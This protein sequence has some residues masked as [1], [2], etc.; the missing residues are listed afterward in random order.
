MRRASLFH[1]RQSASDL[2]L[3]S[4][5]DVVFQLLIFFVW[6]AGFQLTEYVLPSQVS[7]KST[8]SGT[9]TSAEP[10][11]PEADFPD[12]VVRILWRDGRVTWTVNDAGVG[13]LPELRARLARVYQIHTEAPLI[14]HPDAAVPLGQVIDVYDL[15]RQVGFA[16]IQ[17]AAAQ[18]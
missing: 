1:H 18:M 10:P 16:K 12:L 13:T 17:F 15:A 2:Q 6:T 5:I 9:G 8:A 3:T 4:L 14:V 11:P 7:A